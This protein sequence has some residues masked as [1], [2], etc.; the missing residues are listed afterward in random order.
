MSTD[1]DGFKLTA[2]AGLEALMAEFTKKHHLAVEGLTEQQLAEAIRQALLSGDFVRN[3]LW[4]GS[5]QAVVYVPFRDLERLRG[6]YNELLMAVASKY[7]GED[8]H[9]TAL[10]YIQ[11]R[12]ASEGGGPAQEA[13]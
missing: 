9:D 13:E 7:P 2:W 10:R 6:L 5:G 4:D 1:N 11:E 8:R 12:E 3:V